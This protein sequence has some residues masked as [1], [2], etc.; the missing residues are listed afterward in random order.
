MHALKSANNVHTWFAMR[1][2]TLFFMALVVPL[3]GCGTPVPTR[4]PVEAGV[5]DQPPPQSRATSVPAGK[6]VF[7]GVLLSRNTAESI[8]YMQRRYDVPHDGNLLM[9]GDYVTANK[10]VR[11]PDFV[12]KWVMKSLKERFGTVRVFDGMTEL[13]DAQPDVMA[14]LDMEVQL[15]DWGQLT[16]FMK[17]KL[18]FYDSRGRFIAEANGDG[19]RTYVANSASTP[20][21]ITALTYSQ[22]MVLIEALAAL[23]KSIDGLIARPML[24]QNAASNAFD[25]CMRNAVRVSDGKLRMQAMSACDSAK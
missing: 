11:D 1:L 23:D 12:I 13:K 6:Q 4:Q 20:A 14:L 17:N 10:T 18:K 22:K 25:Q 15:L 5:F 21:Q 8:K 2:R 9:L 7:L 16:L 3:F 19:S 24:A